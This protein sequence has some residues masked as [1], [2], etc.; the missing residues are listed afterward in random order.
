M[1][2]PHE[3][4]TSA[5]ERKA[6]DN[7]ACDEEIPMGRKDVE[8]FTVKEYAK[9]MKLHE[10]SVLRMLKEKG[11]EGAIKTG[12]HWRIPLS[13]KQPADSSCR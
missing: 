9:H 6:L 11:I 4:P 8:Y 10:I 3:T 13:N 2:M 5:S 1:E 12:R 7:K